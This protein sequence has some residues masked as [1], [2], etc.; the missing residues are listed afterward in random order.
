MPTFLA[1]DPNTPPPNARQRTW[2][3]AAL[4]AADGLLPVGVPTRS[5]NVLRERGWIT[6]APAGDDDPMLIRHKI[7]PAGRFA[8]L[9]VAKADALLSTL[10]SVEPGRI[11]APVQERILDSLVREGLVTRL[12]RRGQQ[13]EDEEQHPYIT[14]LGRRLVSLPEADDTPAGDYLLAALATSGL[15]ARV[16]TDSNGDSRIVYRRGDVEALFYREVWNPGFY[17]YSARHPAWMHTKPW[18]A[19]V[20]HAEDTVEEH[21]PSG[22]GVQEESARMAASFAAWLTHRDDRAFT[23]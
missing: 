9:S 10:V 8:L 2:L 14:N 6:T 7:T 18:T 5:L 13:A 16:E 17:T 15:E 1:A 4:R 21:M 23:L 20:T 12:T 22:L 19:L 3:L 11:E